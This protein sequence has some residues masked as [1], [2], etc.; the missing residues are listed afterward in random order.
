MSTANPTAAGNPPVHS[1]NVEKN[2]APPSLDKLTDNWLAVNGFSDISEVG[3]DDLEK[4]Y[5]HLKIM[6]ERYPQLKNS[7]QFMSTLDRVENLYAEWSKLP[8]DLDFNSVKLQYALVEDFMSILGSAG[9]E[10]TSAV[11]MLDTAKA[12]NAQFD[13]IQDFMENRNYTADSPDAMIAEIKAFQG[14]VAKLGDLGLSDSELQATGL[15]EEGWLL[16]SLTRAVSSYETGK[17]AGADEAKNASVFRSNV[18]TAKLGYVKQQNLNES[19]V[20][21]HQNAIDAESLVQMDKITD[22]SEIQ[23][24][25]ESADPEAIDNYIHALSDKLSK[26]PDT[27]EHSLLRGYI[28][29]LIGAARELKSALQNVGMGFHTAFYAFVDKTTS[30]TK[31]FNTGLAGYARDEGDLALEETFK[32][33]ARQAEELR[34]TILRILNQIAER[35]LEAYKEIR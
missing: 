22:A 21:S 23:W 25:L 2:S 28:T 17:S 3:I 29:T 10:N 5:N 33:S 15:G 8:P 26:C 31:V 14:S 32:G 11:E 9:S 16:I 13:K 12:V 30:A 18:A 6:L 19:V 27:P 7:F 4:F 24:L 34:N 35:W 20:V 1:T